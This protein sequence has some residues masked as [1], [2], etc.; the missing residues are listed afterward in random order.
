MI[1]VIKPAKKIGGVRAGTALTGVLIQNG[2]I[3]YVTAEEVQE[4]EISPEMSRLVETRK[5]LPGRI[6]GKV[7]EELKGKRE[8]VMDR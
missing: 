5:P 3:N 1:Q 7:P 8:V 4:L 2:M 6:L